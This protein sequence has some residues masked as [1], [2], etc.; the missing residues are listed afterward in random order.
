[1]L[2]KVQWM[3]LNSEV[4]LLKFLKRWQKKSTY[5]CFSVT[6]L[7]KN[8]IPTPRPP[9]HSSVTYWL[10][11]I[12]SLQKRALCFLYDNYSSSYESILKL[13]GKSTMNVTR[14]RGLCIKMFKTLNSENAN[15]I[16]IESL[17]TSNITGNFTNFIHFLLSERKQV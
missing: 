9:I 1:M 5:S 15:S 16:K 11:K 17:K 6:F 3:L 8:S 12:Q 10:N 2:I 13:T 7:N 14:L 4:F